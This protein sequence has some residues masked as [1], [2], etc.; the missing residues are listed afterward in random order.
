MRQREAG[1]PTSPG[2]SMWLI[3]AATPGAPRMSYRLSEVTRGS[4]L[5]K[6]ERGW[7]IPPP[8]PRTATLLRRATDEEK[9]RPW[10]E[11]LRTACLES[12]LLSF[13][14]MREQE[15]RRAPRG[16]VQPRF[17]PS[18]L[19][20]AWSLMDIDK[21]GRVRSYVQA[22]LAFVPFYGSD[23]LGPGGSRPEAPGLQTPLLTAR[24]P[25][26]C[27]QLEPIPS[28]LSVCIGVR[29]LK[30][31][32]AEKA[33]RVTGKPAGN[34]KNRLATRLPAAKDQDQRLPPSRGGG[35]V[36]FDPGDSSE[37]AKVLSPMKRKRSGCREKP[38]LP[39]GLSFLYSFAPKNVGPS[40]LTVS[41]PKTNSSLTV[42]F[43]IPRYR[44]AI[45]GFLERESHLRLRLESLHW[46]R[47]VG[48]ALPGPVTLVYLI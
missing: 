45:K 18:L 1:L 26:A 47:L 9:Q 34:H 36:A 48:S 4:A 12:I 7:P 22:Q 29:D 19:S 24:N 43:I 44:P 38:R 32:S 14:G 41:Q 16:G 35:R 37:P 11:R 10:T 42:K 46:T 31:G 27:N 39:T 6:R 25:V 2:V 8:A 5:S 3:S 20:H 30:G 15:T 40:R 13:S 28:S 17:V 23:L 33:S 21:S